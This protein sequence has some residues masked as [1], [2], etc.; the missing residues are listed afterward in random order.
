[1]NIFLYDPN[2][3]NIVEVNE[4]YI[5][6]IYLFKMTVPTEKQVIAHLASNNNDNIS[7]F[8]TKFKKVS[9]G[10]TQIKKNIS[11]APNKIP[12]FNI[13]LDNMFIVTKETG[14]IISPVDISSTSTL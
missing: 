11:T 6:K 5:D 4:D 1:M 13:K 7:L 8:F 12:L 3:N 14:L 2:I 9:D 10:I